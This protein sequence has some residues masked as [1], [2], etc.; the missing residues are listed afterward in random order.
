[1]TD[2]LFLPF[3]G[4]YPE[5]WF[6]ERKPWTRSIQALKQR[7]LACLDAAS[8]P[9]QPI[10]EDPEDMIRKDSKTLERLNLELGFLEYAEHDEG[11]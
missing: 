1:M 10:N 11:T 6:I 8:S 3:G 2:N 7:H 4:F 9:A 5:N